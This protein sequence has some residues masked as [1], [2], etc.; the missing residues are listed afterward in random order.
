MVRQIY[1]TQL[2]SLIGKLELPCPAFPGLL[3]SQITSS[4]LGLF[5]F[6]LFHKCYVLAYVKWRFN[7]VKIMSRVSVVIV[8]GINGRCEKNY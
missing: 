2:Y 6:I 8:L 3:P 7:C 1:G 4:Y 5:L